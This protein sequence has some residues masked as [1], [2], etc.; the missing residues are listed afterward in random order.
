MLIPAI[1]RKQE[2][3]CEFQK[4][5]YTTEMM[6]MQGCLYNSAPDIYDNSDHN[7][8]YAIV[9]SDDNLIGFLDYSIDWY[10]SC[11]YNFGLFSFKTSTT[12]GRDL[13]SEM[14]RII[15][16]YKLHRLEWQMVGGNP[17][18]RNYDAFCNK[19]G[20]AKHVLRDSFKDRNGEY[21]DR[22]I[23]EIVMNKED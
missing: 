8:Q 17:V 10:S 22:V 23:Y 21:H 18:E 15:S 7:F 3:E 9:D 13:F 6:Y 12:V 14:E 2:I 11:A 19:Y 20:G 1:L 16:E 5:F 4:K